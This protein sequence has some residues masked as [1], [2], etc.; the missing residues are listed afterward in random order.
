[1]PEVI[2]LGVASLAL[3]ALGYT[4]YPIISP[5]VLVGCIVFL[6]YPFRDRQLA[7]RI[8]ALSAILFLLWFFY[9]ILGLLTPFILAFLL[10]YILDPLVS[11]LERRGFPRWASSLISV[12]LLVGAV[13]A[14]ILFLMPVALQQFDDIISGVSFIVREFAQVL[15]SGTVFEFLDRYGIPVEKAREVINEQISP[16]LQELLRTLF[17]GVFGLFAGISNIV[18][19]I[20]NAVIVPFLVFYILKDFP[21]ILDRF[22]RFVP[23]N[24]RNR[25]LEIAQTVDRLIGRY[26][27]GAIAVA[28]I[29]GTI[30]A[31]CLTLIGVR[32]SLVLGIMTGILN[33]IPYV[34]LITSLVVSCIV[35][36]FSGGSVLTKVVLVI[37]L[38]LT[39]KLLEATILAPKIIGAQVG[40][41][42]V[43]LILCLLV[44]GYFL[45]FVGLLIAVPAT[46]LI[47]AG[48]FEWET[49]KQALT[50]VVKEV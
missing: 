7:R 22:V 28:L 2:A 46:A 32:F 35:A 49:R 47:I 44:F 50:G 29:Q 37:I 18:L 4:V 24:R 10:A 26:I 1:M 20:I 36:L 25:A 13:V 39:Q 38:Y 16:R 8:I 31:T 3:V 45:G 34:G 41:H 6:L 9:S 27:R 42:P 48:V 21:V 43:L 12:I 15:Q 40:L 14:V 5:F 17:L 30:S 23:A 11:L 19:H 33:F